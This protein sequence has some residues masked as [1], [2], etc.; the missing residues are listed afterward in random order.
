MHGRIQRMALCMG[1]YNGPLCMAGY[2]AWRYAWAD[3]TLCHGMAWPMPMAWPLAAGRWPLAAGRW[4]LAA[5]MGTVRAN[6]DG[7]GADGRIGGR[8]VP[9]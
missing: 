8:W 2:N 9:G 3:T 4:P 5:G 1:G 7:D 6:G